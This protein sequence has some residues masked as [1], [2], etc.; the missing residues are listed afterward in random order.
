MQCAWGVAS[1]CLITDLASILTDEVHDV[2]ACSSHHFRASRSRSYA[3]QHRF[4]IQIQ[5]VLSERQHPSS[6][7][8]GLSEVGA[9]KLRR[10]ETGSMNINR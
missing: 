9:A 8:L 4:P 5:N 6:P 10:A 3:L 1:S 7:E 2:G